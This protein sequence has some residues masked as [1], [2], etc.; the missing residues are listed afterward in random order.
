M[1]IELK[2]KVMRGRCLISSD[3][4]FKVGSAFREIAHHPAEN[5]DKAAG[6][7][8]LGCPWAPACPATIKMV[9]RDNQDGKVVTGL[10]A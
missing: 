1:Q 9:M 4:G 5:S 3:R 10:V 2:A 6:Q 8:G 7:T